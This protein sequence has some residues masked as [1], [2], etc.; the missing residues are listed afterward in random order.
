MAAGYET[1]P[2]AFGQSIYMGSTQKKAILRMHDGSWLAGY[3]PAAGFTRQ[4]SRMRELLDL[5]ARRQSVPLP[6][7]KWV[8]F[9]RDFNSG[10]PANPERLLRTTFTGRPRQAGLW[11]RMTLKDETVLEGMAANDLTLLDPGGLLLTPP[12]T[13]SNTQR[14]FLPRTSILELA[15]VAVIGASCRIAIKRKPP[16]SDRQQADLFPVATPKTL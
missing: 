1:I 9:V 4:G 10:E 12:D 11:L 3:L 6:S 14:I 7:L 5:A 2:R 13:R 16:A 8:C 15:V